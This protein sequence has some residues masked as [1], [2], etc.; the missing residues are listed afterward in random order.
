MDQPLG[1]PLVSSS[2]HPNN[3]EPPPQAMTPPAVSTDD[4]PHGEGHKR[5][6]GEINDEP[7]REEEALDAPP[8]RAR[9]SP[10]RRRG[11]LDI[12]T[13]SAALIG[14][15]IVPVAAEPVLHRPLAAVK[16]ELA[17]GANLTAQP[18]DPDKTAPGGVLLVRPARMCPPS[19]DRS[20]SPQQWLIIVCLLQMANAIA[21]NQ[22]G[23]PSQV[24]KK[25]ARTPTLPP[26]AYLVH[27]WQKPVR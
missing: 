25:W 17:N 6:A 16:P 19:T 4:R 21:A 7:R 26:R 15:R 5:P 10:L 27:I 18:S 23:P 1:L 14:Q 22:A 13:S 2:V 24:A 9:T 11:V 3:I 12:L 20:R 8:K